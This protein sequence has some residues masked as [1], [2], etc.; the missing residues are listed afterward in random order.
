MKQT[1]T[2]HEVP[3]VAAV[4]DGR[5]DDKAVGSRKKITRSGDASSAR[6][7][8]LS[9]LSPNLRGMSSQGSLPGGGSMGSAL[10]DARMRALRACALAAAAQADPALPAARRAQVL[11]QCHGE[12]MV[13][14]GPGRFPRFA[15][16]RRGLYGQL[17]ELLPGADSMRLELKL[18]G[19]DGA[20]HP[21][22]R[23]LALESS[24]GLDCEA[25]GMTEELAQL[26]SV[27][28]AAARAGWRGGAKQVLAEAVQHAVFQALRDR[29]ADGY[30][31]GRAALVR[32]P[33]LPIKALRRQEMLA[34]LE[35]YGP[36]PRWRQVDGW[37]AACPRC[38]W[39]MT[40]ESVRG[41][42]IMACPLVQHRR[43][44]GADYVVDRGGSKPALRPRRDALDVPEL[45]PVEGYGAVP[46]PVWRYVTIPGLLELDLHDQLV[47]QGVAV[48]LWPFTDLYDLDVRTGTRFHR[49]IDVKMWASAHDLANALTQDSD[50]AADTIVIP[51][52]QQAFVP[53]LRPLLR[54]VGLTV[55]T[56]RTL[57]DKATS[58]SKTRA[59]QEGPRA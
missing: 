19:E 9:D 17:E 31:A 55:W 24:T 8:K 26:S 20:L 43:D 13:A 53:F 22:V 36:I 50:H 25:Q 49:K 32:T 3:N 57:L 44:R 47:A 27:F 39:P 33:V 51:D 6:A 5:Q 37:W 58:R 30:V 40:V 34:S 21:A 45:M 11:M 48:G 59:D 2:E 1:N 18:L 38:L 12:L 10:V 46:F 29:G 28:Q 14:H 52:E 16:F 41:E 35:I 7:P 23:D 15:D 4:A 42:T 54:A 56:A